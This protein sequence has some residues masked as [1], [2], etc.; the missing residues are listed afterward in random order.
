MNHYNFDLLTEKLPELRSKIILNKTGGETINF[1]DS[2]SVR[3]LNKAL[4]F[5][6][7]DIIYWDFPEKNLTPAYPSR[8]MYLEL[9]QNLYKELFETNPTK[10]LDIGCGAS[11][12]YPLIAVKKFGWHSTASDIDS[13]SLKFAQKIIDENNLNTQINLRQQSSSKIYFKQYCLRKRY[14]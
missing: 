12:I 6:E 2:K 10:L 1:S 9:C 14:F 3:L 13:L 7:L 4:L 11:L 5:W 8:F